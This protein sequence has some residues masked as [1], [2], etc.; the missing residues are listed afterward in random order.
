MATPN[1]DSM[2]REIVADQVERTLEPYRGLLEKMAAIMGTEAPRRRS[3][4]R[5]A[6]PAKRRGRAPRKAAANAKG[7]ASRFHEGQIVNYRQGR[8]EFQARVVDIDLERNIVTVER[9]SD[10]HRVERPAAKLYEVA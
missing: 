10:Q 9:I 1:I 4:A 6:G 3:T 5:P 2:I 8:G 7:D